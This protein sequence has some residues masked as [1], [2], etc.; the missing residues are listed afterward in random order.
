MY[1]SYIGVLHQSPTNDL[2]QFERWFLDYKF[3]GFPWLF[4]SPDEN[5]WAFETYSF[6]D[7]DFTSL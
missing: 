4:L 2:L 5:V 7:L 3:L 6:I 1:K